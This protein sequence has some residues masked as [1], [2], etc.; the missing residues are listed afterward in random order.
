MNIYAVGFFRI[1]YVYHTS[2]RVDGTFVADLTA[3]FTIKRGPV[4]NDGAVSVADTIHQA[5]VYEDSQNFRLGA[6]FAVSG[7]FG[8][9]KIR[10]QVL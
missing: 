4:Q 7:K 8:F 1:V 6:E 10:Q 9:G 5:V 3:A 2:V